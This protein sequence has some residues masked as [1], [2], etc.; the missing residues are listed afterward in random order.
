MTGLCL[1]TA[2]GLVLAVPADAFTLA[3]THSIE[4]IPWEE[5]Y[6]IE[7]G[8][9]RLAEARIQGA[10]A[11]MEP[12]DGAHL[13]NGRWRYRPAVDSLASVRLARHPGIA[14]FRLCS[15]GEC[16][17]IAEWIGPP[18]RTPEVELVACPRR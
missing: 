7:A 9:L 11:G 8:R 4:Q 3:W 17:S 16:R 6:R 10:G 18:E 15:N 14:D 1:A 2:A 5:D 12:P 13:E